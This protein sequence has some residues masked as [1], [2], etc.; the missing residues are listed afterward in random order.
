[1]CDVQGVG[2][3][4]DAGSVENAVGALIE[5]ATTDPGRTVMFKCDK[6]ITKQIFEPVLGAIAKAGATIAAIGERPKAT[7]EAQP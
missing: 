6:K 5:G 4:G 2:E 3:Q 1:M 7:Q